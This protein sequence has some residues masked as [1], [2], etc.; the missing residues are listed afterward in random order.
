MPCNPELREAKLSDA[1]ALFEAHVDSVQNLCTGAYSEEQLAVWFEDRS[2]EIY[3][4]AIETGQIWLAEQDGSVL[5]FVGFQ[6]GE[7]TLLFVRRRASG[8]GIGERLFRLGMQK[9][10]SGF[11]GPLTVVATENSR[12]FYQKFGFVPVCR[13]FF[14]RGKQDVHIDVVVMRRPSRNL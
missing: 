2:P 7:I 10:E 13:D 1:Q 8:L 6:A 4:T 11:G 9:A 12:S 14:V 5:G 3:R